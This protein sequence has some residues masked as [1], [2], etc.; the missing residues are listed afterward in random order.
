MN[1]IFVIVETLDTRA[2][3]TSADAE[4]IDMADALMPQNQQQS[5]KT[6]KSLQIF[7]DLCTSFSF[8]D[9]CL[10]VLETT[11]DMEKNRNECKQPEPR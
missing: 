1:F 6:E 3:A 10:R 9:F 4:G 2:S 7:A 5:Y 11:A 8:A